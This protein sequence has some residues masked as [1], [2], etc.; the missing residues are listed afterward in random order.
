MNNDRKAARKAAGQAVRRD[1]I[2]DAAEATLKEKG[3]DTLSLRLIATAAGYVP[4]ALYAYFPDR[5]ALIRALAVRRLGAL[6]RRAKIALQTE[7]RPENQLAVAG[8]HIFEGLVSEP[9]FLVTFGSW[10]EADTKKQ[11]QVVSG[12]SSDVSSDTS[13]GASSSIAGEDERAFTGRLIALLECLAS[14]LRTLT[15]GKREN[16]VNRLVVQLSATLLGLSLLERAGRLR[17]LGMNATQLSDDAVTGTLRRLGLAGIATAARA[18]P[19]QKQM[20]R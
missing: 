16:D 14:P 7:T 12:K 10:V 18:D 6:A 3:A 15:R 13:S 8:R 5:Q 19:T 2:L 4:A 17:A 11:D 1:A 20:D 9:E